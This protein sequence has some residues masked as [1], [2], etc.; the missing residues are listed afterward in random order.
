M[1]SRTN[2]RLTACGKR[3]RL[4]TGTDERKLGDYATRDVAETH[5]SAR[6]EPNALEPIKE[7]SVGV[8]RGGRLATGDTNIVLTNEHHGDC[9]VDDGHFEAVDPVARISGGQK[10]SSARAHRVEKAQ[11]DARRRT[12]HVHIINVIVV[13]ATVVDRD[14]E[15][16]SLSGVEVK[17]A[18]QTSRVRRMR[19]HQTSFNGKCSDARH[20][21]AAVGGGIDK[22]LSD[23]DLT[24]EIVD[25]K[26]AALCASRDDGHLGGQRIATAHAIDL[27][28]MTRAHDRDERRI[29]LAWFSGQIAGEKV[30]PAAG[31]GTIDGGIDRMQHGELGR[32]KTDMCR[33]ASIT[34]TVRLYLPSTRDCLLS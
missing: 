13:N 31:A 32:V 12:L 26:L 34:W 28:W 16:G 9:R 8:E 27:Q 6:L 10:L 17:D 7:S 4:C 24:E 2:T 25:V 33:Q 11:P 15:L 1:R 18:N 20:E 3:G 5:A 14:D 22:A 29:S 30:E 23:A 21:I 19:L